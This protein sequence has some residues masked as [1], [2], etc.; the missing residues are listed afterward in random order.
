MRNAKCKIKNDITNTMKKTKPLFIPCTEK[1]KGSTAYYEFQYCK[2]D[3]TVEQ[4]VKSDAWTYWAEDSLLVHMDGEHEL[5]QH[6][7]KPY[8]SA[9]HA[10]N[11]SRVYFYAGVNY[12]TRE[13]TAEMLDRIKAD[14][15]D[16]CE[17]LIPWLERAA[18]ELYGFYI[19]GI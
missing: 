16:K 4:A 1:R 18:G 5:F 3:L 19:L 7:I 6:Y 15:P 9:P 13:E 11:G 12:Y 14:R 17:V 2:R 8:M 10:P